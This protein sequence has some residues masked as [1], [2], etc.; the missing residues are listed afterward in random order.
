M[1]I[2]VEFVTFVLF[3]DVNQLKF[4]NMNN[5]FLGVI[6]GGRLPAEMVN[7]SEKS[8]Q[9]TDN[10]TKSTQQEKIDFIWAAVCR[11][12]L[13]LLIVNYPLVIVIRIMFRPIYEIYD[14]QNHQ[15]NGPILIYL[16][17][18]HFFYG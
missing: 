17:C 5:S 10:N 6:C 14:Q 12:T 4:T 16:Q 8:V 2:A 3:A 9:N 1:N 15:I 13:F 18:I 11:P 7:K